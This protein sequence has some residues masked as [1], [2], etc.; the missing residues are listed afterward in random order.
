[1]FKEKFLFHYISIWGNFFFSPLCTK[2]QII[3]K[4]IFGILTEKKHPQ[5]KLQRLWICTYEYIHLGRQYIKSTLYKRFLNWN[6][7][8]KKKKKV[9]TGKTSFFLIGTFILSILFVLT[10]ASDRV[11]LHR[12]DMFSILVLSTKE[13]YTSFLEKVFVFQEIYFKVKIKTQENIKIWWSLKQRAIL[14]ISSTVFLEEPNLLPL[15]WNL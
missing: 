14:K 8:F 3:L 12:K 10:L 9:V 5:I 15:N 1:M 2:S 11:A 13:Q 7:I 6:K 4:L